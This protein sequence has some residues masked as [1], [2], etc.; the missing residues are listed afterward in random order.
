[1]TRM[2]PIVFWLGLAIRRGARLYAVT[3]T[4]QA[5]LPESP[6]LRNRERTLTDANVVGRVS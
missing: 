1:M 3:T 5:A 2:T 6:P 4:D